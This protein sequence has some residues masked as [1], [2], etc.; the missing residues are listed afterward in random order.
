MQ[1]MAKG[2]MFN[3]GAQLHKQKIGTGKRLT[4][5][6]KAKLKKQREKRKTAA[7]TLRQRC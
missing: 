4:P 2:G 7:K 1:E 5:Q 6:E 3:P